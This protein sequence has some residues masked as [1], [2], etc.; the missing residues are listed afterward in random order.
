MGMMCART[1]WS[2][3]ISARVMNRASRSFNFRN[4]L[5][6]IKAVSVARPRRGSHGWR[7][8]SFGEMTA[9]QYAMRAPKSSAPAARMRT[10]RPGVKRRR[11]L[12]THGGQNPSP[13]GLSNSRDRR[14][15]ALDDLRAR[16]QLNLDLIRGDARVALDVGQAHGRR[17]AVLLDDARLDGHAVVGHPDLGV[18]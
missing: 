1:G 3:C 8:L 14:D 2:V 4:V 15:L 10:K 17:V 16:G 7:G 18:L 6:F 13:F 11:A 12:T 9:R 5:R